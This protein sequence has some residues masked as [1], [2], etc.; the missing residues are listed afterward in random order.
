MAEALHKRCGKRN[1]RAAVRVARLAARQEGVVK[2]AQLRALGLDRFAVARSV[3]AAKLHRR[4]PGVYLVGHE[5]LSF[6]GELIAA[7]FYAGDGAAL[8]H[9]SAAHWWGLVQTPPQRIHISV[10]RRHRPVAG[11]ALH[12][13]RSVKRVL[14]HRLPVTPAA[15]TLLDVATDATDHELRKALAEA[16]FQDLLDVGDLESVM[17]RGR[18][19]SRRLRRTYRAHLPQLARTET[20]LEDEF[21]LLCERYAIPLPEPNVWIAGY[22]VDAIWHSE[23]V[24][25]ELDGRDAHSSQA[26]RLTDHQ[27]DLKLR[28]LGYVVRR[29]SWH[30]VFKHP[31]DVAADARQTL[32]DRQRA[33]ARR[34]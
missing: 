3:D 2:E 22:R 19:G 10:P 13:P 23:R 32:G 12:H 6:K 20:P 15:R 7:L 26:R 11:I 9:R 1:D 21:V 16:D 18:R 27:R 14:H 17:R 24:I 25:V 8:S 4:Y 34:G 29:Y 31:A 30:Q 5:A 33:L 28:A